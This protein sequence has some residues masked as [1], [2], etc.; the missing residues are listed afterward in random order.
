M[1]GIGCRLP[2][3]A[4]HGCRAGHPRVRLQGCERS[5]RRRGL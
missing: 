2:S 5:S 3:P 1:G 4:G